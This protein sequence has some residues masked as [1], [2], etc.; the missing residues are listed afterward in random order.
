MHPFWVGGKPF[1][2]SLRPLLQPSLTSTERSIGVAHAVHMLGVRGLLK[3][4]PG[5][6]THLAQILLAKASHVVEPDFKGE[7][8]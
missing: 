1:L 7:D 4:P 6:V 8:V 5:G 2:G 3:L